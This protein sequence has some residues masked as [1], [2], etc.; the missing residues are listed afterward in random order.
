VSSFEPP[1]LGTAEC[2]VRRIELLSHRLGELPL[3]RS[4]QIEAH[5]SS[6]TRCTARL[7]EIEQD[8]ARARSAA[9]VESAAILARLEAAEAK[10]RVLFGRRTF[11]LGALA[12]VLLAVLGALLV[13]REPSHRLKGGAAIEMYVKRTE[14]PVR[15]EDGAS[16]T[17]G[18]Q[19]QFRYHA[20]GKSWLLV[21]SV[22]GRRA[23]TPLYPSDGGESIP[24][25]PS[26]THVLE[27]SIILDDAVGVERIFAFFS[28]AP[29][30]FEE[31]RKRAEETL[32]THAGDLRS[33]DGVD[34]KEEG[35]IQASVWFVKM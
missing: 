34:L 22:D 30:S 19:V 25:S 35:V 24:V 15:A 5:L 1:P 23:I 4:R 11:A 7:V 13:P 14:G 28:D 18:D 26:G 33:L 32:S 16:L 31:V 29:L 12:A 17:Q 21:L 27:G 9:P 6:C 20:A 8:E 2:S 10:P 3:D